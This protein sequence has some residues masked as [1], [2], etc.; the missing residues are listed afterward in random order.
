LALKQQSFA[1]SISTNGMSSVKVSL[2]ASLVKY[3]FTNTVQTINHD[4]EKNKIWNNSD[5][6][7]GLKTRC[8]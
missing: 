1:H 3:Q 8:S 6:K 5:R 4:I 7:H 2:Q